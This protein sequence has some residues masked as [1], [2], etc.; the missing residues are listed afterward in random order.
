MISLYPVV[1]LLNWCRSG[2]CMCLPPW[3]PVSFSLSTSP[4]SISFPFCLAFSLS[5]SYWATLLE[6]LLAP[7]PF[8]DLT[9]PL[10]LSIVFC[11]SVIYQ[12]IH[13]FFNSLSLEIFPLSSLS[14][15]LLPLVPCAEATE[16]IT[17]LQSFRRFWLSCKTSAGP[18]HLCND[19]PPPP[20]QDSRHLDKC[21]WRHSRVVALADPTNLR[22]CVGM[23]RI[24]WLGYCFDDQHTH[25]QTRKGDL[26][27]GFEKHI[28][29]QCVYTSTRNNW[30][31][32]RT[33]H[34]W[35]C[36]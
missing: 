24:I 13:P 18:V 10:V 31:Q 32:T 25:M 30:R 33:T 6:V 19:F 35:Q 21:L 7:T 26:G 14:L 9:L 11:A 2:D 4:F 36:V 8:L 12:P 5:H 17:G 23:G 28:V 29:W 20:P 3:H 16:L 34:G 27:K 1:S 15:S 22:G